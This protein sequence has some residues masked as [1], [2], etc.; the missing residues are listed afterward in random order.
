[1]TNA[2]I[3]DLHTNGTADLAKKFRGEDPSQRWRHLGAASCRVG[4]RGTVIALPTL[5]VRTAL[6]R[7]GDWLFVSMTMIQGRSRFFASPSLSMSPA[8]VSPA[9]ITLNPSRP[10]YVPPHLRDAQRAAP[11]AAP[12]PAFAPLP[13]SNGAYRPAATGL[14]TPAPTPAP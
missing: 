11:A 13:S 8:N 6:S 2:P 9:S 4:E 14:P 12:A 10:A 3:S 7:I 1:M 5:A